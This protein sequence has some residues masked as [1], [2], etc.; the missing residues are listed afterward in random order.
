MKK[1]DVICGF[2]VK[3]VRALDEIKA[4]MVIMEFEKTGTP[5]IWLDRD[6]LNK[7][8]AVT[9]KT[10]P[11]DDTGVFHIIE[12]S[13]L[14]GS[15]KYPVKEPFVELLKSSLQT[16]LNAMTFP[17][18]TMYPVSSRNDTDFL[19]LIDVYLDAVLH[20]LSRKNPLGFM[21]EGWHYETEDGGKT[22][23]FNGVVFNEMKGAYASDETVLYS[24]MNKLLFPDNCY[25]WESGGHPEHIT[26]LTYEKYCASHARFYHPSNATVILDGAVDLVPVLKKIAGYLKNFDRQKIDAQIPFQAPVEPEDAECFYEISPDENAENKIILGEGW[27]FS[28]FDE[29]VKTA[30][31]SILATALC[32]TNESPLKKALIDGGL[33]EDAELSVMDGIQQ[34]FLLL[35]LRN[36][37]AEKAAGAK[38]AVREILE[39]ILSEGLDKKRLE[40]VTDHFEYVS[41]EKDFGTAPRGLV[42]AIDIMES[43]LY[44]GDP[45]QELCRDRLFAEIRQ[46][47]ANGGF[48]KL[49]REA[50]L[51]NRHTAFLKM[52]PSKTLGEE[53]SRAEAEKAA[54][55]AAGWNDEDR[56]RVCGDLFAL[57][58]FQESADT[59]EKLASLPVLPLEAISHSAPETP[60]TTEVI[61]GVTLL[62]QPIPTDG[63]TYVQYFFDLGD[64]NIDELKEISFW[65]S[66][67]GQTAT[68]KFDP[69]ELCNEID[70]KLGHFDVGF[71][72]T[73]KKN[74]TDGCLPCLCVK[75]SLLDTKKAQAAPLIKEILLKSKFDDKTFI[76]NLLHQARMGSERNVS[77]AGSSVAAK[78]AAAAFSAKGAVNEAVGGLEKLRWLQRTDD[79]FDDAFPALS[80]K[81]ASF[82][83]KV[84]SRARLTV[85]VTGEADREWLKTLI[86]DLPDTPVGERARYAPKD[87]VSEGF[88][89]P[90]EIGFAARAGHFAKIGSEFTGTAKVASQLLTYG[91]LWN[92]IRVKGGA[93]GTRLY[94]SYDGNMFV[95]SY[96]DPDP[97]R[98][99]DDFTCLGK[100]LRDFCDGDEA[101]DKYIISTIADTEPLLTPRMEGIMAA[102]RYLAGKTRQDVER[103]RNEILSAD[104][105]KLREF[106]RVLDAMIDESAVCVVG[107][108]N[109]LDACGGKLERTESVN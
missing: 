7:T 38:A 80:E 40:A 57:R 58:A 87:G 83:Q 24:E 22:A 16:F 48:E 46:M 30:A 65:A 6:D 62:N 76:Y 45:A 98:S 99:L 59:P 27:V 42:Y 107:G 93:Y 25:R 17:D 31:A 18:K 8:F 9:F 41:R 49:L 37:T 74:E 109:V 21:Q 105:N 33:C 11:E 78:R 51:E 36:T 77:G 14:N 39:R 55:A 23:S 26:E 5:L 70:A 52:L 35:V 60:Q 94:A 84:F 86:G 34:E 101:I 81:F 53:K 73:A 88:R 96:R 12:H 29:P 32:G 106:S 91:F 82:A 43:L 102:E 13:V 92:T 64:I 68:E 89:I 90:A 104:K 63:I 108:K 10:V 3:E 50:M 1:N 19:N 75:F 15:E 44:G 2:T 72:V 66:V 67:L 47:I 79:G 95:T 85:S 71:S 61:D 20:P 56:K 69:T 4:K 97:S 54:E 28:R 100:A 103:I